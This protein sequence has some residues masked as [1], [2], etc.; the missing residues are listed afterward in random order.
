MFMLSSLLF[1]VACGGERPQPASDS[2]SDV[3]LD[4][5]L[6]VD[7]GTI[8]LSTG[9]LPVGQDTVEC[10]QDGVPTSL[11]AELTRAG[12]VLVRHELA[13]NECLEGLLFEVEANIFPST[14]DI[15]LSYFTSHASEE[16]AAC[17][18]DVSYVLKGVPPGTWNLDAGPVEAVILVP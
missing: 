8:P 1:V 11:S 4:T 17:D 14:G 10:D 16:C 6:P 2:D 9:P 13:L 18:M 5:A 12:D 7:S 15:E 3:D